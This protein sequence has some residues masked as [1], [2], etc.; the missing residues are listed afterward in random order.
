MFN[1]KTIQDI[2]VSEKKVLVRVDF[3]V[4]IQ[5]GKVGDDTRIKA[6][7]PTI[8]YLLDHNASLIL[9]SH[10]GR[11]KGEAKPEFSLKPVADYLSGLLNQQVTFVE[12]CIGPRAEQAA[13]HL[14]PKEVLL[15]ENTRFHTGE[16]KNDP[17]MAM[18]LAGLADIY[19]NDAFGS[20]HRAHA[21]TEGV[22][23]YLPSVAGYLLEKEIRYLGQAIANPARP[24]LAILGGAKISDKIGVIRNLL[25]S[26]DQVLIGGGMANTFFKAQGYPVG[27]SLV[28]D[29]SLEIA[30]DLIDLAKNQLRLPV[31]VVIGDDFTADAK[32]TV[33]SMGPIPD[34]WR[35]LDIGPETVETFGKLISEAGTVVWNG[36]MGVFEFP[37]FAE[38][39]YGI[40]AAVAE[41]QATSIIGGGDSVAAV[42]QA[43]LAAEITH[44]STGGGASLEMLEGKI[45]PGMAA[46][47]DKD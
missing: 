32:K 43:G 10:L 38:G 25:L 11:P 28:E 47:E 27:D 13:S 6:A 35:I 4:P 33:M 46:L 29:E 21:S 30:R 22:T 41:S 37:R 19:V 26:A 31:D 45:L 39:T 15:L 3:N 16:K 9:C 18:Q 7:L 24:F 20:A 44:I 36:P 5:D 17:E 40:A 8:N 42:N 2:D 14:K 1:K 23:H 12:D 34:G